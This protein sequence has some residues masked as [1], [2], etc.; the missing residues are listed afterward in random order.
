MGKIDH[1]IG[2]AQKAGR[3]KSGEFSVEKSV[4]CDMSCLV[5][6][7]EDASETTKKKFR[8]MCTF[9]E[10]PIELY[11]SKEQMGAV[12]GRDLR[13]VVS[14]EDEGFANAMIKKLRQE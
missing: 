6:L 4:K 8:N 11:T 3:V 5:L 9:Y 2:L 1:L 7:A 12:I 10:V 13:S 14:V